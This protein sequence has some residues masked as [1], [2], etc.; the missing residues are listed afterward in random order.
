ML[1]HGVPAALGG[2]TGRRNAAA[3]SNPAPE[4]ADMTRIAAVLP[5]PATLLSVAL[6]AVPALAQT[7]QPSMAPSN[8]QPSLSGPAPNL[9]SPQAEQS[10]SQQPGN[11]RNLGPSGGTPRTGDTAGATKPQGPVSGTSG[12]GQVSGQQLSQPSPTQYQSQVQQTQGQQ[13]GN[14]RELPPSAATP[15]NDPSGVTKPQG[16]VSAPASRARAG[17]PASGTTR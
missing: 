9:G 8:G 10:Q 14:V 6:F 3:A 15:T 1:G 4:T 7:Q 11:V 2:H 12:T 13:P 17:T 5:M 16:P